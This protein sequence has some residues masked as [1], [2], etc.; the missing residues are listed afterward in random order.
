MKFLRLF[1]LQFFFLFAIS[2]A[3][4]D[5][6]V[7]DEATEEQTSNDQVQEQVSST[8]VDD[9]VE[10]AAFAF[11]KGKA[12]VPRCKAIEDE[13][14][15]Q[16]DSDG[17]INRIAYPIETE[18]CNAP[19]YSGITD[20]CSATDCACIRYRDFTLAL[21]NPTPRTPDITEIVGRKRASHDQCSTDG[22]RARVVTWNTEYAR[23]DADHMLPLL[24][25]I[26]EQSVDFFVIYYQEIAYTQTGVDDMK[27]EILAAFAKIKHSNY[28]L[29]TKDDIEGIELGTLGTKMARGWNRQYAI[30]VRNRNCPN[31]IAAEFGFA[32][33]EKGK[34]EKGSIMMV[35][36]IPKDN[37][38]TDESITALFAGVHISSQAGKA[39]EMREVD[40][41]T[42]DAVKALMSKPSDKTPVPDIKDLALQIFNGGIFITGDFNYRID[43]CHLT[44]RMAAHDASFKTTKARTDFFSALTNAAKKTQEHATLSAWFWE[45]FLNMPL[46]TTRVSS[47]PSR[48]DAIRDSDGWQRADILAKD[49]P[50]NFLIDDPYTFPP[51]YSWAPGEDGMDIEVNIQK[52]RYAYYMA[53]D[54][55]PEGPYDDDLLQTLRTALREIAHKEKVAPVT[56]KVKEYLEKKAQ[57]QDPQ[58]D[59]TL[60]TFKSLLDAMFSDQ[61]KKA[62]AHANIPDYRFFM[63]GMCALMST[64]WAAGLSSFHENGAKGK[65]NAAYLPTDFDATAFATYDKLPSKQMTWIEYFLQDTCM[66]AM[67]GPAAK[68]IAHAGKDGAVSGCHRCLADENL[69]L[70]GVIKMGYLDRL[71]Y[72]PNIQEMETYF[73]KSSQFVSQVS[74]HQTMIYE[75]VVTKKD[76][77]TLAPFTVQ[78]AKK[79]GSVDWKDVIEEKAGT[80][81]NGN[82]G[83]LERRETP[84]KPHGG[85]QAPAKKALFPLTDFGMR[86]FSSSPPTHLQMAPSEA[87]ER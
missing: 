68:C 49:A 30:V 4:N 35:V 76:D 79:R 55:T 48:Y 43:A 17:V 19:T 18:T 40:K 72:L 65:F 15:K 39:L 27:D 81:V 57:S 3:S 45:S 11:N 78:T 67:M 20:Q 28:V 80:K 66:D 73:E 37:D 83:F 56:D 34:S 21:R 36:H 24:E 82:G 44:A 85:I 46:Y 58:N 53:N 42:S 86:L 52:N 25:G 77:T 8:I 23:P 62:F 6:D 33:W 54:E 71:L 69:K 22:I 64:H 26:W 70:D 31:G 59:Q 74:D 38:G 51:G 1:A 10:N 16:K 7:N 12:C 63:G 75:V 41:K 61:I 2:L 13:T 47:G 87:G 5:V 29:P 50:N 84:V 60:T 14:D 9:R 32:K